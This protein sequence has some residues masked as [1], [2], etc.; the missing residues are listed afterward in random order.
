MNGLGDAPVVLQNRYSKYATP[1]N[2]ILAGLLSYTGLT[3]N[4]T[5]S[6]GD[7]SKKPKVL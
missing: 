1:T 6:V 4:L 2:L 7:K 5:P 3:A